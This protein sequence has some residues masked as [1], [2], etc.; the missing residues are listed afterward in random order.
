MHT[1][2]TDPQA[3]KE[4]EGEGKRGITTQS[5]ETGRP[6]DIPHEREFQLGIIA[7]GR[8]REGKMSAT[9]GR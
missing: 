5:K 3:E 6:L 7:R 8:V 1:G 2:A 9:S 4:D